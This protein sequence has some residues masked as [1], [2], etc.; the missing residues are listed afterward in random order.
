MI[1]V[2]KKNLF[3]AVVVYFCLSASPAF[4]QTS[5]TTTLPS[6]YPDEMYAITKNGCGVII[7]R[8]IREEGVEIER[9]RV[10]ESNWTG[11]CRGALAEGW[12]ELQHPKFHEWQGML[13]FEYFLGRQLG[14]YYRKRGTQVKPSEQLE[15]W[16]AAEK[17]RY[18]ELA[19]PVE[20]RQETKLR[21]AAIRQAAIDARALAI[22]QATDAAERAALEAEARRI[23]AAEAAALEA[24]ETKKLAKIAEAQREVQAR[25]EAVAAAKTKAAKAFQSSLAKLNAGEL[26]VLATKLARDSNADD[27]LE[28][29]S[30]LVSRFPNHPLAATAAQQMA[31]ATTG[32]SQPTSNAATTASSLPSSP[33]K[34]TAASSASPPK[35]ASVCERNISKLN[36]LMSDRK[37]GMAPLLYDLFMRDYNRDGARVLEPCI[38][39][40]PRAAQQYKRAIDEYNRINQYCSGPHNKERECQQWGLGASENRGGNP[41]D[42]RAW[43]TAWKADVDRALADPQNFSAELGTAAGANT[44]TV[45]ST[46][47]AADRCA[48]KLKTAEASFN[49]AQRNIPQN[50]VVLRSEALMWMLTESINIIESTC[51]NSVS[52][53]SQAAQFRQTLAQTKQVCDRSSTRPCLAQLPGREPAPPPPQAAP[54]LKPLENKP[55]ASCEPSSSTGLSFT[56]CAREACAKDGGSFAIGSTGCAGCTRAGGSWTLCPKGSSGVSSAQ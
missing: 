49:A 43:Y 54:N 20:E 41:Y 24:A 27:A 18:L 56:S 9:K 16:I 42:N 28:A 7:G 47:A 38:Q 4:A 32:A 14:D 22:E 17:R 12:G 13:E 3:G 36:N 45:S 33:A 8:P 50:S 21:A 23:A 5:T 51:P 6:M 10:A 44:S 39:E 29:R 31:A 37:I 19:L 52:Y 48:A 1:S 11:A 15:R 26:F 2:N 55:P 34:S 40:S 35:Y 53:R 30:A 25:V 46:D